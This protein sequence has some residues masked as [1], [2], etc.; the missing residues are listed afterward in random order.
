MYICIVA[1]VLCGYTSLGGMTSYSSTLK[2]NGPKSGRSESTNAD[3][4][5]SDGSPGSEVS[6]DIQVRQTSFWVKRI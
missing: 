4:G 1:Y 6:D 5:V 2:D 3:E